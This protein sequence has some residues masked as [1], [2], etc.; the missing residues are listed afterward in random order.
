[1]P[2][3]DTV[4]P[5]HWFC[6]HSD[7]AASPDVIDE[8]RR[9]SWMKRLEGLSETFFCPIC[10]AHL[11][12]YIKEHPIDQT[13]DT[14]EKLERWVYDL[15]SWVN[16][17]K[18]VPTPHT[19]EE[20]QKAFRVGPWNGF[21]GYPFYSKWTIAQNIFETNNKLKQKEDELMQLEA[22]Q[23]STK[24]T[25]LYLIIAITVVT[26][27]LLSIVTLYWIQ[28]NKRRPKYYNVS[29]PTTTTK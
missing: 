13:I 28:Q 16:T 2:H 11:A 21:G 12:G 3:L 22:S 20:V 9:L 27:L 25:Q 4:G 6:L 23:E 29:L 5:A 24:A 17:T 26:F 18:K 19:F 1:M 8:K 15:H 14:R 10:G 7:A